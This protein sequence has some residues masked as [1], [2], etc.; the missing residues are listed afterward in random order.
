MLLSSKVISFYSVHRPEEVLLEE[1]FF[2][3]PEWHRSFEEQV[4]MHLMNYGFSSSKIG[5]FLGYLT[6]A[7]NNIVVHGDTRVP[8]R[9]T[10]TANGTFKITFSNK[11]HN[12][13]NTI[14]MPRE[15]WKEQI[16]KDKKRHAEKGSFGAG[17]QLM[18]SFFDDV[19]ISPRGDTFTLS[20][21]SNFPNG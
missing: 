1:A 21:I 12:K 5:E 10:V 16:Y 11:F 18:K 15:K 13:I 14:S 9:V 19:M 17:I 6:E 3:T 2:P 8:A 4:E 7:Y 20:L